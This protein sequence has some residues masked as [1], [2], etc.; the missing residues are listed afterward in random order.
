MD[1]LESAAIALALGYLVPRL[2]N[3]SLKWISTN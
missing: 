2:F 3:T 1:V